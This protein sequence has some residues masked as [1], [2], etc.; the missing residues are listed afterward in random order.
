LSFDSAYWHGEIG[1]IK[2]IPEFAMIFK[3]TKVT[4]LEGHRLRI[5]YED[6]AEGVLDL[7]HLAGKGV[8][9]LWNRPHAC[10]E[11]KIGASGEIKWNDDVEVCSDSLY[12]E[13]TGKF[14][15]DIFTTC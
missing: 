1:G 5:R 13:I 2:S 7:S 3:P 12:L 14:P 9:A 8:F 4:P 11:V 6:G 15:K 10:E